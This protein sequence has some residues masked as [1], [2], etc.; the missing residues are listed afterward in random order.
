MFTVLTLPQATKSGTIP[1]RQK[2]ILL[3]QLRAGAFWRGLMT[4]TSTVSTPQA[5]PKYGVTQ[6]GFSLPLMQAEA[7]VSRGRRRRY[8]RG[9][10]WVVYALA[11]PS[12]LPS[13]PLVVI[14][15]AAVVAVVV[16]VTVV[17]VTFAKRKR[18]AAAES[19]ALSPS[20]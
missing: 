19:S 18:T 1:L 20:P 7:R 14:A 2:C 10:Q 5:A 3:P 9:R 11:A 15:L 4:V 16:A 8:L 6:P 12:T 13:F 17:Y